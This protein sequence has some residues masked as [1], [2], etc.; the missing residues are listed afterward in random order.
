MPSWLVA[1]WAWLGLAAASWAWLGLVGWAF[2]FICFHR[3]HDLDWIAK[4]STD[5]KCGVW[6]DCLALE[7]SFVAW[8]VSCLLAV[9]CLLG[10][11]GSL[12]LLDRLG[13]L[14][15]GCNS[16]VLRSRRLKTGRI[17]LGAVARGSRNEHVKMGM[18][19]G[20]ETHDRRW[21]WRNLVFNKESVALTNESIYHG[22]VNRL[23]KTLAVGHC[24]SA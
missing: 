23:S 1:G 15:G 6:H 16:V 12:G 17:V 22:C 21:F 4:K 11:L 2:N 9:G 10:L 14:A 13:V 5:V 18:M 20:F 3:F 24:R 19:P 7:A 8:L